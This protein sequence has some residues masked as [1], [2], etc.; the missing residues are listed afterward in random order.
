MDRKQ[1]HLELKK[2]R[3]QYQ[4]IKD[5]LGTE[6][7]EVERCKRMERGY[8]NE[9][10]ACYKSFEETKT[11]LQELGDMLDQ[12]KKELELAKE[13]ESK[14]KAKIENLRKEIEVCPCGCV[15]LEKKRH[16]Y[17]FS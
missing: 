15:L 14:R 9:K 6:E 10:D 4:P 11:K 5:R 13:Q 17:C 1:A 12:P 3:D 2:A 8:I 7:A 16:G